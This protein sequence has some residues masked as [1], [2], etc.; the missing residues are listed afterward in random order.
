MTPLQIA[1]LEIAAATQ[2]RLKIA[3]AIRALAEMGRVQAKRE[4]KRPETFDILD[5]LADAIESDSL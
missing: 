5:S 4:G 2:E 1:K 3:N